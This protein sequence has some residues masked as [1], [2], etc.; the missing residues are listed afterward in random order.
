MVALHWMTS[1]NP[2]KLVNSGIKHEAMIPLAIS[3]FHYPC[4]PHKKKN[5]LPDLLQYF[6]EEITLPWLEYCIE[7]LAGLTVELAHNE[8]ITKIIPN[9]NAQLEDDQNEMNNRQIQDSIIQVYLELPILI[10]MTW[11]WLHHLG[12]SYD[13]RKKSSFVD[14]HERLNVVFHC[15]ES[16]Q[17]NLTKL[18]PWTHQR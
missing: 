5:N 8:L 3:T 15:N 16:C 4:I 10:S 13:T 6:R 12:F 14:G 18:K 11:C 1:P 2:I 9:A 7:N 17:L